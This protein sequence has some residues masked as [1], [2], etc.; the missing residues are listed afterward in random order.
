[1]GGLAIA[2]LLGVPEVTA[3]VV[4]PSRAE[5]LEPVRE[6]LSLELSPTS[7]RI[8]EGCSR[9]RPLRA[10]RPRAARHG[11]L[12]RGDDRGSRVAR[13]R[14]APQ[15]AALGRSRRSADTL[16]GLMPAYRGGRAAY[17]LKEIV[18]VPTDPSRGLD[19]HM[20]G[21]LLH[22]GE[23]GELLA[24]MNASPI[25]EIRTAAVSAVATRALARPDAQRVAIL[26]SGAQARGHV[27]AMRAV[28][29]DPEIRI[30]SRNLE[31]RRSS[32]ASSAPPSHRPSTRLSSAPR[33]CARRPRRSS[34]SSSAAGSRAART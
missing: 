30:W 2:W 28:L 19:T 27:H 29:D 5:H 18:I 24:I 22:D 25:T 9:D 11:V 16:L 23:T 12:R 31:R 3:V 21:V 8:C 20:G 32:P 13:A 34:R 14:R 10:R 4:G 15:P 33:S 7:T 6:A 17:G 1:M 26:G